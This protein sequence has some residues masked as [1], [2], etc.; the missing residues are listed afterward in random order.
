MKKVLIIDD[1]PILREGLERI[2]DVED[3]FSV[4]GSAGSVGE[5][6]AQVEKTGPDLVITDL[7]LPGRSG[8]ELIKDLKAT[9][10]EL[11]VMVVSMHDEMIYAE[12]VLK[13]GGR[14]Y[15]MKGAFPGE[16]VKAMH[17]VL[18]G[19]VY[20]SQA[21]TNHFLQTLSAGKGQA[22]SGY[23]L[24]RLT[25]REMEVFDLIGQGKGNQGIAA[26][27]GIS[28]RTVDAHRVHI[29]EKLGLSDGTALTRYAV[30]WIEAG[31]LD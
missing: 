21:V 31:V 22:K 13:A 9:R 8:L 19:E 16:L 23:P 14:G 2:I 28:P 11:P 29:R 20:A 15:L 17:L 12:R 10:P 30:R 25:D 3:D 1:H 24:D 5:A 18:E 4:C 27:L 7:S 6:L 26:R